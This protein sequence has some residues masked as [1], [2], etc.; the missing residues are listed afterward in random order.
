MTSE[1]IIRERYLSLIP[2]ASGS[3]EW[4]CLRC[5]FSHLHPSAGVCTNRG[6]P[7]SRLKEVS[8]DQHEPDYFEWL[9]DL[10]AMRM[11]V[12]EL[13]GQTRP[14]SVQRDRQRKFKQAFVESED[15]RFE[16][17]DVL[18]VTTTM[19]VGVD[20]G[21]LQSVMMANM[22]PQRFN[23]QQRVGRAGRKGQTFSH[24][25]TFC[26]D[27]THDD[28]YFNHPERITGDIPAEPYLSVD[29]LDIARRVMNS[30]CLRLAF[31]SLGDKAPPL[32]RASTHGAFGLA[33]EW[34][35]EFRKPVAKFL[36]ESPAVGRV[37][38]VLSRY[39][40]IPDAVVA[41]T[42]ADIRTKLIH[43]IDSAATS[44]A[45]VQEQL[46]ERLANEG[47]LPMFGFPTQ[48][49][50]LW[51]GVPLSLSAESNS[52]ISSRE[53]GIAVSQFAPGSET[54]NDKLVHVSAGFAAWRS[55][56]NFVGPHP[57]PMGPP[58]DITTC[59]NCGRLDLMSQDDI[60]EIACSACGTQNPVFPMYQPLGFRTTYKTEDY[61]D[62][63][64]RGPV[65]GLPYLSFNDTPDILTRKDNLNA[66]VLEHERVFTVNSNDGRLF[67]FQPATDGTVFVE[68]AFDS[69][70]HPKPFPKGEPF[71][72][73]I[74]A[75]KITDVL[76]LEFSPLRLS[77]DGGVLSVDSSIFR[78]GLAA[79]WSFAELFKRSAV[80]VLE[81]SP[82]E[83][84][85]G[86][87][88]IKNEDGTRV[89]RIFLAD[90]LAN[91]AGY[92]THLGRHEVFAEVLRKIGEKGSNGEWARDSLA[93][94]FELDAHSSDCL[95]SC[96]DCLRSYDNRYLHSAL[97]WRLALDVAELAR[98]Y[99]LDISRWLGL[100]QRLSKRI[101]DSLDGFVIQ[102]AGALI[103]VCN[104]SNNTA[105][106]MSHPLWSVDVTK[107]N[108]AQASAVQDLQSKGFDSVHF[109]DVWLL[110]RRPD[111][112]IRI[113]A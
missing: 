3:N 66:S 30:E 32:T 48:V 8:S 67:E 2:A 101:T 55:Q 92:A 50:S 38:E 35:S 62:E 28:F 39:T 15:P 69:N 78:S 80:D 24:A 41:T 112:I 14:L 13:T 33:D 82:G 53:L 65:T 94:E 70:R 22:P 71:S 106:V 23:Y 47:Y 51:A 98:G 75:I 109:L 84:T 4:R 31:E 77:S 1:W 7:S 36:L 107:Y 97:D 40:G 9:S 46:S 90:D 44:D 45:L 64:E 89:A 91:G 57:D 76:A 105:A 17:I 26:R 95:A 56:G 85:V 86:L 21:S 113:L 59:E 11:R 10:Q 88:P 54:V 60:D 108:E 100:S 103:S 29:R 25:L 102:D 96:P 72:G 61:D 73:A 34:L 16:G 81:I 110:S 12:E 63:I 37:V 83:L 111:E 104:Q 58:I 20:I 79:Y 52:E 68:E 49:R 6:C 19:E 5:N 74:G 43:Q 42:T 87:Q 27:R 99:E 18:S 93:H